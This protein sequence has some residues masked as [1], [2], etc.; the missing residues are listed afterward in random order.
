MQIEYGTAP[1]S[2]FKV[3]ERDENGN[4]TF[5][6]IDDR[7]LQPSSRFWT[8]LCSNYS[9]HGLSLKLFKLFTHHE[10]FTRLTD[11]IGVNGKD[12]L[13]YA[14][15]VYDNGPARLLAVSNPA[16]ALVHYESMKETL[17][18]YGAKDNAE[19][20]DGII[21]S[22]HAPA[23]MDDIQIAGDGFA[24]QYVMETPIDSYGK[25]LIYLS[26]LRKVCSNGMIGYARAFRSE[27]NIGRGNDQDEAMFSI[28]RA[29]DRFNNEEGYAALTER[30][31]I[32]AKSWASVMETTRFAKI[33]ENMAKKNMFI[34]AADPKAPGFVNEMVRRKEATL[35]ISTGLPNEE[36]SPTTIKI[37]RAFTQ[38]TGD[39]CHMYNIAHLDAMSQKKMA[40]LPTKCKV[41]ELFNFATE[42]ATHYCSQKDGRILNA[43][44]GEMISAEYDLEL[45]VNTYP[46]YTDFF[47]DI[48]RDT[49]AS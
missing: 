27:I 48:D 10:V 42:V 43:E 19:Y 5:M 29:L 47:I 7:P 16:K 24:H 34:E 21:R 36:A 20:R 8:S 46:N 22:T 11:V 30:Y 2:A 37:L 4:V 14:L 40:K 28:H 12:R 13:R 31:D 45:T 26:L 1:I 41:Y 35:G 23:H 18:R 3:S 6:A 39:L 44:M 9:S 32:A 38:M 25:P 15:E 49:D 33:L 17:A